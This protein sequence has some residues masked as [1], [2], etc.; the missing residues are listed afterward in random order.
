M[1][2]VIL[3]SRFSVSNLL[4]G[5]LNRAES[6]KPNIPIC[7]IDEQSVYYDMNNA[8]RGLA[9]IFNHFKFSP[10]TGNPVRN[11]TEIDCKRLRKTF[12]ELDFEVQIHDDLTRNRIFEELQKGNI[13]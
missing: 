7:T 9:I 12:H 1:L 10:S 5:C 2:Q 3:K 11:G 4:F 13:A 6:P 8:K